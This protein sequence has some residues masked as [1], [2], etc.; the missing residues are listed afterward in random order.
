MLGVDG[1]GEAAVG[2]R[3]ER[4]RAEGDGPV[5]RGL[6]LDERGVAVLGGEV[7]EAVL[8]RGVEVVEFGGVGGRDEGSGGG[9]GEEGGVINRGRNVEQF[10]SNLK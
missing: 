9:G 6:G 7:G 8:A 1:P 4:G 3:L 10:S 2:G 5:D